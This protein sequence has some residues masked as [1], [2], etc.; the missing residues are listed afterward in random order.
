ML[1]WHK[2]EVLE[3]NEYKKLSAR[4]DEMESLVFKISNDYIYIRKKINSKVFQLA[5]NEMENTAGESKDLSNNMLLPD[6]G[7]TK[8]NRK[9]N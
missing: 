4:I 1:W 3:S 7:F 5:A 9:R 8:F 6:D 2:K